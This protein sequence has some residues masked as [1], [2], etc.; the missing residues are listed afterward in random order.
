M[1]APRRA[2]RLA[3]LALLLPVGGGG[4]LLGVWGALR[5]AAGQ[6]WMRARV[7]GAAT[8]ALRGGAVRVGRLET[9]LWSRLR[10]DGLRLEGPAGAA[11]VEIAALELQIDPRA[12]LD[13]E[14]RVPALAARGVRADL[15]QDAT[16]AWDIAALLPAS[17]PAAEAETGPWAG[18]PV[19]VDVR[20]ITVQVD[21][22]RLRGPEGDLLAVDGARLEAAARGAGRRVELDLTALE[23]GLRA[24][25]PLPVTASGAVQFDAGTVQ[26]PRVSVQAGQSALVLDGTVARVETSP[27]LGLT[28]RSMRLHPDDLTALAG[29]PVLREALTFEGSLRGPLSAVALAGTAAGATAGQTAIRVEVDAEAARTAWGLRLDTGALDLR[30]L[31]VDVPEP[32]LLR[33]RWE[34][35]GE[36]TTWPTDLDARFTVDAADLVAWGEPIDALRLGGSVHAG[37]VAVDQVVV[38]HALGRAALRGSI[39]IPG[40]VARLDGEI[41]GVRL[42]SLQ[43]YGAPALGGTVGFRGRV[44]AGWGGD[45]PE[46]ALDGRLAG[47]GLAAEGVQVA[48]LSGPVEGRYG[49]AGASGTG[50]LALDGV[51]APGAAAARLTL[52]WS[53]GWSPRGG[54]TAEARV[55]AREISVGDGALRIDALDGVAKG[56]TDAGGAVRAEADAV[57]SSL[58][59]GGTGY[60]AEG[61]PV[62]VRFEPGRVS[63]AFDLARENAPFFRGDVQGDLLSGAWVVDG[64]VLAPTATHPLVAEGP[65]RFSLVDGG[66]RDLDLRLRS[67][68]GVV[69]A[70]GRFVPGAPDGSDLTIDV[71]DLDLAEIASVARLLDSTDGPGPL[72]GVAG[73]AEA[74]LR[75][76]GR[77]NAPAV[78][79]TASL[80]GLVLPASLGVA[81]NGLDADLDVD[82]T[83]DAPDLG[84]RLRGPGGPLLTAAARLPLDLATGR[85]RCGTDAL[86]SLRLVPGSLPRF[87]AVFPE[88]DFPDGHGGAQVR[89]AGDPCDPAIDVV[90][91]WSLPLGANGEHLRV[92]LDAHRD[93][94]RLVLS[95]SVEEGFAR[96]VQLDGEATTRLGAL[97]AA[98]V[99]GT[100][101]GPDP[102][103]LDTWAD[104]LS[105]RIVPLGVPAT[106]LTQF[107]G[108]PPA[109]GGRLG[110]GLLVSGSP[111]RPVVSGAL[112]WT[113]GRVGAQDLSEA[114]VIVLPGE[115]GYTVDGRLGFGEAGALA[116]RGAVPLVLDFASEEAARP[117]ER[118]GLDLYFSGEGVPL[119]VLE[120][121]VPEVREAAGRLIIRGKVGGSL[122]AP[123]PRLE[124]AVQDGVF[125]AEGLGLRYEEL[126]LQLAAAGE[127]LRIEEASVRALP[128]WGVPGAAIQKPPGK[129]LITGSVA[130]AGWSPDRVDLRVRADDYWLVNRNDVLMRVDGEMKVGGRWPALQIGGD[131]EMVEGR[132]V[133]DERVFVA[134]TDLAIDPTLRIVRASVGDEARVA[135]KE[136]SSPWDRLEV[137][138]DLDLHRG[139]RLIADVPLDDSMGEQLTA[140]STVHLDAELASPGL[141]LSA[142]GP[143]AAIAGTVELPRG[144]MTLLGASFKV[145]ETREN[146]LSFLGGETI[147]PVLDIAAARETSRYGAVEARVTGSV[148]QIGVELGS[149]LYPDQTD[150]LSILLFGKPASELTDSEGQSGAQMLGSA[151][152]MV[153]GSSINRVLGSTFRGQIEMDGDAFRVGSPL[154]DRLFLSLEVRGTSE[155]NENPALVKLEWLISRRLYA[156]MATGGVGMNAADVYWRWRF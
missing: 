75:A 30:A 131:L 16:G 32:V 1:A 78:R 129:L 156:E 133:L 64:L 17:A 5:T 152:S 119:R 149:E 47:A 106:T 89:V 19:P 146:T 15:H 45:I 23:L 9:D 97:V 21:A 118:P 88:I 108:L 135:R 8:A 46:I 27:A 139:L 11:L 57:V 63:A 132:V 28:V 109:L 80:R 48:A 120:G 128:R 147:D 154:G 84:L 115:G 127:L 107:A 102:A 110:G 22:L 79:G 77:G 86:V 34:V 126:T 101:G 142:R 55:S 91:A 81:V 148:S 98:A 18:L 52:D 42:A 95:G 137:D 60:S 103:A 65:V 145:V 143:R 6:E 92:D 100:S 7:E 33:G 37:V 14:L 93:G 130:G 70:A 90:S 24:P 25:V 122:A 35:A 31:L 36:G 39:D 134:S 38:D 13:G 155:V 105:L 62:R 123:D 140:L 87:R 117:L 114:Q 144:E 141:R 29:Q 116:V 96:R 72:D 61:G 136:E 113:D 94:P 50:Q 49:A 56:G 125:D 73:R 51:A 83:V 68:S 43:R 41:S 10:L 40:A 69:V 26:V 124:V 85:P 111:V 67:D 104:A 151:L 74:R 12:V 66:V 82:G 2:R 58:H 4:A 54:A 44:D 71:V 150:I 138:L 59:F 121:L 76:R 153:A 99:Q 20:Q 53:A 112:L 3:L